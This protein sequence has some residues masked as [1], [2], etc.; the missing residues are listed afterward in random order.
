M[1]RGYIRARAVRQG[2]RIVWA[3]HRCTVL[4]TSG[5]VRETKQQRVSVRLGVQPDG[6]FPA[7]MGLHY[8]ADENVEVAEGANDG[9]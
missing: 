4:A 3:G 1:S 8:W 7:H 9:G 6:L 2:D 5:P